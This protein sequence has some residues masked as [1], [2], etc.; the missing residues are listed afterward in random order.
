MAQVFGKNID[1]FQG[2][3]SINDVMEHLYGK[4]A[5]KVTNIASILTSIGLVYHSLF[6]QIPTSYGTIISTS[7]LALYQHLARYVLWH[8]L[9]YF[10][11]QF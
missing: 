5:R 3:I 6:F 2:C 10:N 11:L 9:I 7:I 1:Q 8:S 4:I